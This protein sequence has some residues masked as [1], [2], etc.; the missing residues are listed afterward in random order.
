MLEVGNI[1]ADGEKH[2]VTCG[3]AANDDLVV[4]DDPEV[5]CWF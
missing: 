5:L 2:V 3:V 1:N 4:A